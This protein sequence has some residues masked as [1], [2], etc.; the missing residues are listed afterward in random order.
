[1]SLR[2]RNLRGK[3]TNKGLRLLECFAAGVGVLFSGQTKSLLGG[4]SGGGG[5]FG[6]KK[7]AGLKVVF[8]G[9]IELLR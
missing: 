1:M 9:R 2:V 4:S 7:T 5:G 3:T 6:N 8:G